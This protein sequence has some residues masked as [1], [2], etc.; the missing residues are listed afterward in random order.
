V[1]REDQGNEA[2]H[3]VCFGEVG[4]GWRKLVGMGA[5]CGGEDTRRRRAPV[6]DRRWKVGD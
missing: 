6:R 3:Y 1:V 2:N 5:E 4:D